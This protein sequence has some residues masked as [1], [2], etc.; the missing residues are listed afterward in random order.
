MGVSKKNKVVMNLLDQEET[1][2]TRV[3]TKVK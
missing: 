3:I 2:I 1:A